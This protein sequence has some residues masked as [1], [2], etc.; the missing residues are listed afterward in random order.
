LST[1]RIS[2]GKWEAVEGGFGYALDLIRFIR[3]EFGDYF[4]IAIAGYPEGHLEAESRA[5][6]LD[7]LVRKVEAGANLVVTQL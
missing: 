5:F 3:E 2:D 7:V 6:D 4:C 1:L